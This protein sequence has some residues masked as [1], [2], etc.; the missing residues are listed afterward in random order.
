MYRYWRQGRTQGGYEDIDI[1]NQFVSY[2]LKV[3]YKG[4]MVGSKLV[5]SVFG[6][7]AGSWR[8]PCALNKGRISTLLLLLHNTGTVAIRLVAGATV[9][10]VYSVGIPC[11]SFLSPK[12]LFSGACHLPSDTRWEG[13]PPPPPPTI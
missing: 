5:R 1:I 7:L 10:A 6:A 13:N 4:G 2:R 12:S 11:N 9:G 3:L 8:P